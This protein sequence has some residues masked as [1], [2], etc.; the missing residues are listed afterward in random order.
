MPD[1]DLNEFLQKRS[2]DLKSADA[3]GSSDLLENVIK[4]SDLNSHVPV[5]GA[6]LT[7]PLVD[8][9]GVLDGMS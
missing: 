8:L 7:T 9:R 1:R 3:K 5:P 2:A 6:T 4:S